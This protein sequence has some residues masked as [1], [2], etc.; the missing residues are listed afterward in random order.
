MKKMI[1]AAAAMMLVLSVCLL[2]ACGSQKNTSD[3]SMAGSYRMVD[4]A[5]V[6][7]KELLA[8]KDG[9]RLEVRSDNTATLSL[10]NDTH[11]IRFD[12]ARGVC[13]S[14]DDDQQVPYTFDGKQIVMDSVPFRMVFER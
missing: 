11:E 4:A 10:M 3:D 14:P 8:L 2:S 12:P 9:I 13:T 7:S 6:G 5:G 1:A